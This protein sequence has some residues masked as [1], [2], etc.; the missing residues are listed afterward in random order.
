MS[1]FPLPR[2][3]RS[4]SRFMWLVIAGWSG[5]CFA[6]Y[7]THGGT[8]WHYFDQAR[9]ALLDVDDHVR[10]GLHVYAGLPFL[11]FGPAAFVAAAGTAPFGPRGLLV[12]QVVGVL[13][14]VLVLVAIRDLARR[15]RP[16]LS[17]IE[18]DRRTLL[19]GLFVIPV[20]SYLAVSVVHLDD[21]LTL[22]FGVLGLRAVMSDR[23][24]LAGVLLALA[25]DAKPWALP[26]AVLLVLL[27]RHRRRSAVLAYAAVVAVAWLPFLL[28][29]HGTLQAL[30]YTIPNTDYSALRVLGIDTPR[31][32]SWDRPAQIVVGV[33]VGLLAVARGRWPLVLLAA[34]AA[35]VVLDPGTNRYYV[36]GIVV[37]AMVWDVAGSRRSFP[38]WTGT[39]CLALFAARNLLLPPRVNGIALIAFFGAVCILAALPT[40]GQHPLRRVRGWTG[41][42]SGSDLAFWPPPNHWLTG[43][44]GAGSYRRESR[45]GRCGSPVAKWIR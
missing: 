14:G 40:G 15:T 18:I 23:S 31:T 12:A 42:A 16:D 19:A 22:L 10:G 8:S 35:R 20:W 34:M 3:D 6:A 28:G 1:G 44:W 30:R 27:P 25:V 11:Q 21:V 36:A 7:V 26:F 39:A 9:L 38:W 29:D 5:G 32:P 17:L 37:G 33:A 13:A 43:R 24:I 4:L 45:A 41:S 2:P